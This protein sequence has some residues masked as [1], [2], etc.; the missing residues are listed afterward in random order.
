MFRVACFF[1]RMAENLQLNERLVQWNLTKVDISILAED[2][3]VFPIDIRILS[4]NFNSS[5][6]GGK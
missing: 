6:W 2:C 5:D 3:I 1:L 4:G